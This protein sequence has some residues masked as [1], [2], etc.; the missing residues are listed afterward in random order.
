MTHLIKNTATLS[1]IA[2]MSA[3]PMAAF[4]TESG[5][6]Q[7]SVVADP[8]EEVVKKP[9]TG[10]SMEDTAK[11]EQGNIDDADVVESVDGSLVEEDA[12]NDG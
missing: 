9:V 1:L 8:D 2:L 7:Q 12:K 4:A 3:A 6:P 5:S 11:A 10:E